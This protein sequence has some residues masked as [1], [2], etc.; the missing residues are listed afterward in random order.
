MPAQAQTDIRDW[1]H[2]VQRTDTPEIAR[3]RAMHYGVRENRAGITLKQLP[4]DF[5]ERVYQQKVL[6]TPG[7]AE[8]FDHANKLI[9]DWKQS[10]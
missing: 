5:A 3:E 7:V 9:E 8:G 4:A 2:S 1:A 6:T 10:L